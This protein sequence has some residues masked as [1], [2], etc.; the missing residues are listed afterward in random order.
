MRECEW[1]GERFKARL[2]GSGVPP[3][4]C[5]YACYQASKRSQAQES[6]ERS[7]LRKVANRTGTG[8]DLLAGVHGVYEFPIPHG[9]DPHHWC[10]QRWLIDYVRDLDLPDDEA[11]ALLKDLLSDERNI[12]VL[13]HTVHLD[14]HTNPR[15]LFTRDDVKP[16]AFVFAAELG[17]AMVQKLERA[18][19]EAQESAA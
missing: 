8:A 7:N 10:K 19:P 2:A 15:C 12:S 14:G 5:R 6:H 1:C 13:E 18:Y 9:F 16:E 3:T 4:F 17:P 11:R